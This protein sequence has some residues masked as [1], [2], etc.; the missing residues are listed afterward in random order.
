MINQMSSTTSLTIQYLW[1]YTDKSKNKTIIILSATDIRRI[2][3]RVSDED[4]KLMGFDPN[5]VH[6]RNF[7][8][9][10]L[11]VLPPCCRPFVKADGNISD[12]DLTIQYIEIIKANTHLAD[13]TLSEV[14][15]TETSTDYK[16]PHTYYFR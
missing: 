1:F 11:L 4:V 2:F 14:S 13:T 7:I 12:D 6:P 15:R 3:D 10:N 5:M 8:M 16:V 9:S